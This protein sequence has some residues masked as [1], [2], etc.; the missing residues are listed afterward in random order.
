[1]QGYLR[2]RKTTAEHLSGVFTNIE[3]HD[4]SRAEANASLSIEKTV[5]EN[6][7]VVKKKEHWLFCKD[8][9]HNRVHN[10]LS[11]K[12][13]EVAEWVESVGWVVIDAKAFEA[14]IMADAKAAEVREATGNTDVDAEVGSFADIL[15]LPGAKQAEALGEEECPEEIL[16]EAAACGDTKLNKKAKKI[17]VDRVAEIDRVRAMIAAQTPGAPVSGDKAS[18]GAEGDT[19]A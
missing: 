6:G 13:D 2:L 12:L 14:L 4:G 17:A 1:M 18:D 9:P 5:R 8:T 16:R 15:A 19:Q 7:S 10:L 3:N 11:R